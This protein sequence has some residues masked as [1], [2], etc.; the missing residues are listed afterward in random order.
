MQSLPLSNKHRHKGKSFFFVR[1]GEREDHVRME[2]NSFRDS[3]T[4]INNQ[5]SK[6]ESYGEEKNTLLTDIGRFQ[7]YKT[8]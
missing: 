1:H 2:T 7:G 6:Y 8:G 4:Q 3:Q 5:D